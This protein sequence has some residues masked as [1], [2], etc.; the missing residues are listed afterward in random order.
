MLKSLGRILFNNACI[1]IAN[2]M[3]AM[4]SFVISYLILFATCASPKPKKEEFA[5]LDRICETNIVPIA[6][7]FFIIIL[8]FI[9]VNFALHK[10]FIWSNRKEKF[11]FLPYLIIGV[12]A[13]LISLVI[14][15]LMKEEIFLQ[16]SN[17]NIT[18]GFYYAW[19]LFIFTITVIFHAILDVARSTKK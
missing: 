16:F 13:V 11:S 12:P 14:A 5:I 19:V 17:P 9:F 18:N 1:T 6:A 4:F 15:T 7:L 10:E 8:P 3:Y 2:I